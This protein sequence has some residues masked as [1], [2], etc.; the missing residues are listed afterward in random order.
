MLPGMADPAPAQTGLPGAAGGT[1]LPVRFAGPGAGSGALTWGQRELWQTMRWKRTWLPIGTVLPL[2][3]GTTLAQAVADLR[4]VMG[5][6]P[7]LR[8]R[9]RFDPDD[10]GGPEDTDGP[11]QVVADSGQT[12]LEVVDAPAGADPAEVAEQVRQRYFGRAY[13]FAAEWPLRMAVIR[14][15]GAL[16]HRVWVFCHLATDGTG[17]RVILQD[18][19][20]RDRPDAGAGRPAP[21]EQVRWQRSPAGRR[22]SEAA[23]RRWETMLRRLP[24]RRFP[25]RTA[26]TGPRYWLGLLDSPAT[27]LAARVI[28]ART[29]VEVASVFLAVFAVALARV[30]GINPVVIRPTVSNRF[31]PGLARTVSPIIQNGLCVIDVPDGTVDQ[32]VAHTRCRA[33]AGYKYAYHDPVR[34]AEL[35]ARIAR[36]RGE[37]VDLGCLFNDSRLR[38]A[39]PAAPLPGPAQLRAALSRSRFRWLQQQDHRPFDPLFVTIEDV[40]GTAEVEVATDAH[41]LSPAAAAG[42]LHR[43]EE[44]AVAAALYPATR[45]GVAPARGW[46]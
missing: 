40:P 41:H 9:L 28:A 17:A 46:L 24:A 42:C 16:T 8:T 37:R 36:E 29:G 12:R 34:L 2:P 35:V 26:G 13:D 3:A 21:L 23:L 43:M 6:Y 19:A 4:F 5:R 31:R 32:A 25:E 38:P 39:D 33:L 15:R 44:V 20:A 18:L 45:T 1:E 11:V 10:Q 7:S 22:Q 30:T 27:A 14:H